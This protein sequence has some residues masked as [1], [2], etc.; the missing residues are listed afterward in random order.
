MASNTKQYQDVSYNELIAYSANNPNRLKT[1]QTTIDTYK[2]TDKSLEK[3]C[4]EDYTLYNLNPSG[5]LSICAYI[6]D[7]LYAMTSASNR[8]QMIIDITTR[9]QQQ[10]DTLK[11]TH[12]SRKRKKIYDLIGACYNNSSLN[13]KD[14]IELFN[15]ISYLENIHF[16]IMKESTQENIENGETAHNTGYKGDIVFSSDPTTWKRENPIW[17]VDFRA[18]WLAVATDTSV[19]FHKRMCNWISNIE[20]RGWIIEWP[21]VD[22]TKTDIVEQLSR[23]PSWQETDR[24][25]SKD[26]LS[27]RLGRSNTISL[28]MLWQ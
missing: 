12:L 6:S 22:S 15:G 26:Q 10:T 24:K 13:E 28:F 11:N 23:L 5:I 18:R 17:I 4:L 21:S 3:L 1:L 2:Q 9:L 19:D 8:S 7:P 14:T 16:I 20:Q 27:A 25:L